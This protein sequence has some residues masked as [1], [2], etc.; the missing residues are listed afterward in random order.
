MRRPLSA[1]DAEGRPTFV[2]RHTKSAPNHTTGM[3]DLMMC[4]FLE[5][6][7]FSIVHGPV[8][9]T[10]YAPF[11]DIQSGTSTLG[12]QPLVA[13][14]KPEVGFRLVQIDVGLARCDP[15]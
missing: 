3:A 14:G 4:W 13:V 7:A 6:L 5:C 11:R 10:E 1:E 12:E 2:L 8:L 15:Y 9:N